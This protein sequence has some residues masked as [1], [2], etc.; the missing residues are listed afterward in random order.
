MLPTAEACAVLSALLDGVRAD[1]RHFLDYR[2]LAIAFDRSDGRA[3]AEVR[4]GGTRV[5]CE[6][7]AA[8]AAP[9]PDRPLEGFLVFNVEV[10]SLS[11][12]AVDAGATTPAAAE[13]ARM[14]ERQVRDARAIDIE[15]LCIRPGERV[16]AIRCDARVLEDDGNLIDAS[17]LATMAALMHFRRADV[18]I[19]P[20]GDV[21]VHSYAERAPVALPIHHIPLCATFELFAPTA[22]APL[23]VAVAA[24]SYP[25]PG[26][27]RPT[28]PSAPL[29]L[30]DPTLSEEGVGGA[31]ATF[32]MNAHRELC[33][34]HKQGG[35]PLMPAAIVS[36]ARLAGERVVSLVATLRAALAAAEEEDAARARRRHAGNA[37]FGQ[38]GLLTVAQ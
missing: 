15:A 20:A 32:V 19:G 35:C 29:L 4:L 24:G 38:P 17:A 18:S 11:S 1:G 9:Y 25:S 22:F 12:G 10:T 13:I 28:A 2:P 8:V 36:C 26:E 34:V 31:S 3:S 7:V 14:L 16:W 30:L 6:V 23:G 27:G 37:G 21:T 33:G 5:V